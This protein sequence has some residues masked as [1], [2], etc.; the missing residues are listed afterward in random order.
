MHLRL[1]L[2]F[3][4][5]FFQ[6]ING[7]AVENNPSQDT[8]SNS[9]RLATFDIDVTP[10]VGSEMAYNRVINTWDLGLRA[11]GIVLLGAGE[12][13]VLCSIDWI[14]VAN[15]SQDEFKRFL[16]E[17]AG[18]IP[19]RVAVHAIHQHDAPV[20]DFRAEQIL[21]EA[22]LAPMSFESTFTRRVMYQIGDAIRTSITQTQSVTHIGL[23]EVPVYMVASNRRI[24][25]SDGHV[26]ATR[27]TTC[28]DS[29][30]RAE[31]EGLFDPKISLVSF[32]KGSET[33][34]MYAF[35]SSA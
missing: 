31:P 3:L 8:K 25:G 23:G 6:L 26:R 28:T 16:A 20:C 9:L 5:G 27:Y 29:A 21:K 24:L 1:L 33:L 15:E 13:I 7:F 35:K 11:K 4:T 19:E 17:A 34:S 22:G 32:W 2:F 10:P 12:P 30:L 14:G 18:T